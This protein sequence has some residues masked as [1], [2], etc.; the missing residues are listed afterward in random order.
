[1]NTK[2][3]HQI[4]TRGIKKL[5]DEAYVVRVNNLPKSIE[6]AETALLLAKNN[7]NT[8]YIGKSLNNL[9]LFYM[10]RG[11]YKLSIK[12]ADEA[13]EYFKVVNNKRG[14][15]DAK[16]NKAGAYYKTDNFHLGLITL[17]ECLSIY[18]KYKDYH[19]LA[20][21]QK[22]LGTIYEYFG[23]LPNAQRAYENA[24][25]SAIII[26]DLNLE[27]NAYNPLSGIYLKQHDSHKAEEVINW[28]VET[29]IK[30]GDTRGLAFA[31]YGRGKVHLY[32]KDYL[33]AKKDFRKSIDIHKKMHENLGYVMALSKLGKL[34]FEIGKFSE[35]KK[36]FK[37]GM[38]IAKT[39]NFAI[40][41]Y[42]ISYLLYQLYKV[43]NNTKK[44]LFY[45]EKY[46]HFKEKVT[47]TNVLKVIENYELLT[48]MRLLEERTKEQNIKAAHLI[49]RSDELY[50]LS[51]KATQD[52]LWD[53]DL[54]NNI[55]HH[56]AHFKKLFGYIHQPQN[57]KED[58]WF[59]NIHPNDRLRVI[60]KIKEHINDPSC[61]FWEDK[62]R[63][64]RYNK[65]LAH[66]VDRG[67][68]I[69]D[70][71]NIAIRMVG[72]MTDITTQHNLTNERE[73]MMFDLHQRNRD[74]EQF[75]YIISHNLRAPVANI[76]G[77]TTLLKEEK[78]TKP[79]VDELIH[80][81]D[82]SSHS[83]DA[84][85]V[86]L[87]AILQIKREISERYDRVTFS[88]LVD[89]ISANIKNLIAKE[90]VKIVYDFS[91]IDVMNT[92]KSY[93]YSIFFNLITNSIKYRH[94][95]HDPV[96]EIKSFKKGHKIGILFKD[97]GQGID[98]EKNR[99]HLFGLYKRF[100]PNSEGK[101]MGLHMTKTQVETLGGAIT[102]NSQVNSGTEFYLEFDD[103][104]RLIS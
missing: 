27:S 74:L 22:S 33:A 21:V 95:L 15:A 34:Y 83:L 75:A 5:L 7:H 50:E 57:N 96:I 61:E 97:N 90:K 39:Y 2:P 71:Q 35:A 32:K 79:E 10:I 47:D 99:D 20:K 8:L 4:G 30:T 77:L 88:V 41:K 102:I 66:I 1:M 58:Y 46:F 98:L 48:K 16:A 38:K 73:K 51:T 23:D 43:K 26:S 31:L 85:I 29:K 37:Q 42:K 36:Y 69:R 14:I 60:A 91:E 53:W 6:L 76:I 13:I 45:L 63:Y 103:K 67:Y 52:V 89:T 49:K 12:L 11:E 64:Y 24:I 62:Y 93:L 100:H 3:K 78:Y 40:F 84:I 72:A 44:S 70:D 65:E 18:T 19:N 80:Y 86:D 104:E 101:G 68:I 54:V 28:S 87:N 92:I 56:S 25:Q 59:Q 81:L 94:P 17:L 82:E 9:A 55:F